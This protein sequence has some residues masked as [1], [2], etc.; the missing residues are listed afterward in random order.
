[1]VVPEFLSLVSR[2]SA[3]T[4]AAGSTN[5]HLGFAAALCILSPEP[6]TLLGRNIPRGFQV[7]MRSLLVF[8]LLSVSSG[9]GQLG[10]F[11]IPTQSQKV[12]N[13]ADIR[14]HVGQY[15]RLDY[16]GAR[17]SE[18]DWQKLKPVVNWPNNPDYPL[19]DV[20]S[21][22][23][24]GTNVTEAHGKWRVTVTYHM[25]GLFTIGQGYTTE[26]AGNDKE[27]EFTVQEINGELKVIDADP[28]YPHPSRAAMLKW[29]ESKQATAD[30]NTKVIYDEAVKALSAQSGSPFAK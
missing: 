21:R 17:L 26:V 20:V 30:P 2:K 23:D 9:F 15:C 12:T 28:N 16:M 1:M 5:V 29:L 22:Y 27:V 14:N 25:L 19:I 3:L 13:E 7:F 6:F 4:L 10:G 24:I 18:Q 8:M 11:G